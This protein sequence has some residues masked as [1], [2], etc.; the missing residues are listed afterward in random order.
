[1]GQQQKMKSSSDLYG[2]I[3]A[4][5]PL[6]APDEWILANFWQSMNNLSFYFV[7]EVIQNIKYCSAAKEKD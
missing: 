7:R 2:F 6:R 3:G 5:W 1:M 4:F